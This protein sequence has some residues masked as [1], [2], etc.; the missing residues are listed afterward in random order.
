[1]SAKAFGQISAA[2]AEP[3][4][5]NSTE[6]MSPVTS[7]T[8]TSESFPPVVLLVG[9]R[10]D[11]LT[12]MAD[13]FA[14]A[15]F[16]VAKP[17]SPSEAFDVVSNLSP[18]LVIVGDTTESAVFHLVETLKTTDAT[19]QIPIIL[20]SGRPLRTVPARTRQYCDQCVPA[21]KAPADLIDAAGELI[22]HSRAHRAS[23][24]ATEGRR[25]RTPRKA[26]TA[27]RRQSLDKQRNCPACGT[28]LEW[29]DRTRLCGIEYDYYSWCS[30]GCGLYCYERCGGTWVKLI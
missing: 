19:R 13:D 30:N 14:T 5:A 4:S 24:P 29:V 11:S 18:D 12:S 25:Q 16:F 28:S 3:N 2:R 6:P 27:M 23:S 22:R 8:A 9:G 10:A 26:I 1:M 17:T 7:A 21:S 15:G 20:V